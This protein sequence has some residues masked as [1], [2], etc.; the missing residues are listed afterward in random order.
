MTNETIQE[1]GTTA[2]VSLGRLGLSCLRASLITKS[3]F[4]SGMDVDAH[5]FFNL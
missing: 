3:R 1:R 2:D 4:V 5:Q